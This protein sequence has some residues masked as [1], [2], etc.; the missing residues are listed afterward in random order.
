MSKKVVIE[1][2]FEEA[3]AV[4][5]ALVEAQTGYSD[6]PATPERILNLREVIQNLDAATENAVSNK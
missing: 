6:G 1:M 2:T 3:A 4:M 5:L